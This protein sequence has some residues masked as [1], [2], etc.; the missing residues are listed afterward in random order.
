MFIVFG[1]WKFTDPGYWFAWIP[2]YA[3]PYLPVTKT[4]AMYVLGAVETA[5]GAAVLFDFRTRAAS[6]IAAVMLVAIVVSFGW[7]ELMVRDIG[8]LLLALGL[9]VGKGK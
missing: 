4:I 3:L 9:A 8:L 5:I 2:T 6:A 1:I 7:S